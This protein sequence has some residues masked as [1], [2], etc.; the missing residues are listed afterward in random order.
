IATYIRP[1]DLLNLA[2][3]CTSLRQ[4]LMDKSSAFVWKIARR[5]VSGLPDCP[6]DLSEPEYANLVFYAHVA[7]GYGKCA[8]T[9]LWTM[10]RRYCVDCRVEL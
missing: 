1:L 6:A 10:R 7:Q 4:L 2:R 9:I 8:K 3:T 5:Q